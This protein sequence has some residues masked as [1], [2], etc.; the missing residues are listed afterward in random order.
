MS[1][2]SHGAWK[3]ELG[4]TSVAGQSL[5]GY[6]FGGNALELVHEASGVRISF[7]ALE[8]LRSWVLEETIPVRHL[9][10]LASPPEWEY[11][12]TTAYPGSTTVAPVGTQ[13]D[14]TSFYS[15][16]AVDL[17]SGQARPRLWLRH[18]VSHSGRHLT[19]PPPRWDRPWPVPPTS[20][21]ADSKRSSLRAC[22]A[23]LRKPLC[24]CRGPSGLAP[25]RRLAPPSPLDAPA[26][27]PP[28]PACESRPPPA[29][30]PTEERIDLAAMMSS[31]AGSTPLLEHLDLWQANLDP[32]SHSSLQ[33]SPAPR[34]PPA[35]L[36]MPG[37]SLVAALVALVATGQAGRG[38]RLL[39][40][41]PSLLGAGQRS[42]GE[43]DRH[44]LRLPRR[45]G[46]PWDE[47]APGAI[48]A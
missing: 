2:Y 41:L 10:P 3:R 20:S 18:A 23:Q 47:G 24:K 9:S 5:P 31:L 13:P 22:Q 38:A 16:V 26:A 45:R 11:T 37:C 46:G 42:D 33:A 21:T 19:G 7:C 4:L 32:H 39:D 1:D 8:A 36:R 29:W 14:G 43:T 44:A 28:V 15:R 27:S 35:S 30:L 48:L 40:R 34:T 25:L 12:F 17:A 6:L